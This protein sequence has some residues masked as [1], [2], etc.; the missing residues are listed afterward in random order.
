MATHA[1]KHNWPKW[2]A[3]AVESLERLFLEM[4]A[5]EGLSERAVELANLIVFVKQVAAQGPRGQA[6]YQ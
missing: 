6:S 2:S 4:V 1:Y 5:N 3:R